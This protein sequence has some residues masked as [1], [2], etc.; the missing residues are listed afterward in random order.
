MVGTKLRIGKET[1][2]DIMTRA[3]VWVSPDLLLRQIARGGF[4]VK[5]GDILVVATGTVARDAGLPRL[6]V[7]QPGREPLPLL[8]ESYPDQPEAA[9]EVTGLWLP[10][11]TGKPGALRVKKVRPISRR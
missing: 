11:D 2:I 10:G 1:R 6:L 8:L 9:V 4:F 7:D 3:G 5:P